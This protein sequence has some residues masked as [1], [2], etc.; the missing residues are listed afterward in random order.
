MPGAFAVM[1]RRF[2]PSDLTAVHALITRTIDVAY[3]GLYPPRAVGYFKDYH[4]LDSILDRATECEVLVVEC[5]GVLVATGALVEDEICGVFVDPQ[6]QGRGV[7][8]QLMDR[9]EALARDSG[10]TAARLYISLPSRGFYERRGYEVLEFGSL[11]VGEGEHLDYW[12]A[13]KSLASGGS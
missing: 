10:I 6:H 3:S 8:S 13:R 5:D 2:E 7:G 9:L 1:I 11:D 4:S 12:T